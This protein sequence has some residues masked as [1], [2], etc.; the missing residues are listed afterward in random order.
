ML[1]D[2][3][4]AFLQ[5]S[6]N[7]FDRDVVRFLF[8]K[9]DP[10]KNDNVEVVVYRFLRL[11][12]GINV[13][14]FLL[15]ATIKEH[16][17]KYEEAYPVTTEVLNTCFYV[18]DLVTGA[19]NIKDALKISIEANNIMKKA[20]MNLRKWISNEVL[21]KMWEEREFNIL[22]SN[23][24][25]NCNEP[26]KV[27]G[28]PWDIKEDTFAIEVKDLLEF[29]KT[30]KNTKRFVLQVAGRIFDPLGFVTPYTIRIKCLFQELWIRKISW[31]AE[32]PDDILKIWNRWCF[33]LPTLL[34]LQIPR[35]VLDCA[36]LSSCDIELHTFS[37]ASPKA[38]GAVVFV[39]IRSDDKVIVNFLTSK[40]RVAP[41]KNITLPRM[42]LLGALLAARLANEVANALKRKISPPMYF[43]TDSQIALYWIRGSALKWKTFVCN[44][45]KEI[46]ELTDPDKWFFC[47]S[48]DNPS[49]ALTRGISIDQLLENT[50]WW[51]GPTFLKSVN[52]YSTDHLSVVPEEGAIDKELKPNLK[53]EPNEHLMNLI[54][55]NENSVFDCIFNKSN[56][57]MKLI[58]IVSFLY[59][60]IY[61][62][63][64]PKSKKIGPLSID[65]SANAE[66]WLIRSLQE[67]EF[68]DEFKRLTNGKQVRSRSKLSSLNVFLDKNKVM[69]VGGRLSHAD[70]SYATKHPMVLPAKHPLT[71]IILRNV[72]L[73]YLHVGPQALLHQVRQKFWPLN[74]RNSC[75][76]I[77]RNCVICFK[78]RPVTVSQIM[79]E[80]PK[81]R[82]NPSYPFFVTGIDFC[83]PFFIKFKNQRKGVLNKV[84]VVVYVCLSTKAIH[85]DFV[86]DM[87]TQAFIASLKR[88]FGRRGKCSKIITDNAKTF[89]GANVEIKRLQK[90]VRIPDEILSNYFLTEG[91]QWNFIPPRSPN[92][93]GIW[94]AGVKSFKFH[95]KRVIGSQNLTLEEFITILSE[96]EGVLNSR[97]LIPMSS[98]MDNFE[99]LTPGHFL[100]GRPITTLSEPQLI[101]V[102]ENTLSKWQRITKFSQQIW[103]LWK[104]DYLTHLQQRNKWKFSKNDVK[105][106]TLVLIREE[107]LPST[108]WCVGRIIETNIGRDNRVRVVKLCLPS[109][110][111]LI[112]NVRDVCILPVEETV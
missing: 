49:D 16:I 110:S 62:C 12:F 73:K 56:N 45:V 57:Y 6:L 60:F 78:N 15:S 24:S 5:I 52:I 8:V 26:S 9:H 68:S 74:G 32:L 29:I 66:N 89:V 39:L 4:R 100:I 28:L 63:K 23:F 14:P 80:L 48:R 47:V 72:H 87:T 106:G 55:R 102:K 107:N 30:G 103:K 21:M 76:K 93:G 108:K 109:G 77:V 94:E 95:L 7:E 53:T 35:N 59:R 36:E 111:T 46:Q 86:T 43:W 90:M 58:R 11:T 18:D 34:K 70:L 25:N 40:S 67:G 19:D 65:E 92:F 64:N 97:P 82:V 51:Y 22:P 71:S 17:K 101:D 61:N 105:T 13:S 42:E 96:I 50:A 81:D 54:A 38:Y 1:S 88:F 83:G 91:I 3:E 69:R 104:R 75:R 85:L 31:D 41:L 33:E 2:I 10:N 99:I 27:L 79:A 20:S 98:E 84:Y 112:R 44:R 37:D